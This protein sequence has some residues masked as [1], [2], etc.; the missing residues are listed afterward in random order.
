MLQYIWVRFFR[1]RLHHKLV[2]EEHDRKVKD[3][4]IRDEDT[5]DIFDPRNPINKRRRE[6]SQR[7]KKERKEKWRKVRAFER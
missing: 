7:K 4:N 2:F 6:E 3:A 1:Y 5:F